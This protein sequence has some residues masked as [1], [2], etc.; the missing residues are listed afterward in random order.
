MGRLAASVI[1][2]SRLIFRRAQA[3]RDGHGY[4]AYSPTHKYTVQVDLGAAAA[5]RINFAFFDCGCFD[6]SGNWNLTMMP[7]D[8]PTCGD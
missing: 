1:V 2:K 5:E 8:A 7:D 4:P 6:N 3:A